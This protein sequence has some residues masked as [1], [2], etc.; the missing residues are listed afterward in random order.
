MRTDC[1]IYS[2]LNKSF[3]SYKNNKSL[4]LIGKTE[5]SYGELYQKIN[6]TIHYLKS[7]GIK[8]ADKIAILSHNMPNWGI[9]YLSATFMGAVVVP[10]LPDFT[11]EQVETILN[12]SEAKMVFVSYRQAYKLETASKKT[13]T[14]IL[15]DLDSITQQT[16]TDECITYQPCEN[17][18]AAII[19]TSGTTG[20]PKGVMLSHKNIA[21]N[22]IAAFKIQ[23]ILPSDKFLS[24]LP[25]S[26]TYENTL[27]FLLSL[28]GGA[29]MHYIDGPPTPALL[30]KALKA[31][32]PTIVNSVPLIIEKIYRQK[33]QPK[34]TK[35][36]TQRI[37]MHVP[38][39]RKTFHKIAGKKLM[40]SFGGNIKF[41]GVGGA[42]LDAKVE[43]FLIEAKF[44]YAIGYGLTETAPLLAGTGPFKTRL[45]AIGPA[46]EN[47]KMEIKNKNKKGFGEIWVNGPNIMQGYYK[48]EEETKKVLVDGWFN[49]GDIG[50]I[51]NK[52]YLYHKGRKKNIIVGANGENIYPE[53]IESVINNFKHVVES[54]VVEKKGQLVAF[55]HFNKDELERKYNDLQEEVTN[56][57]ENKLEDLQLELLNYVNARMN[58]MNKLQLVYIQPQPFQ[59]TPTQ[60]IKRYLY[61]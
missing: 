54:I 48:N 16:E 42:K 41:F 35:S 11:K 19:Y 18:L 47:V 33:I 28:Y 14:L 55:V 56:Y 3:F 13:K 6:N 31:I 43:Q 7:E 30:A 46:V 8:P 26:H 5:L 37:L 32:K 9:V 52:G 57:F 34:L 50:Y 21:S 49:T 12:H 40:E 2:I 4:C 24:I 45:Q 27:S 58:K 53:D 59:K 39:I 22:V 44:P 10:I 38:F 23:E 25:L 60:K 20:T 61:K 36:V 15:N 17:Q 51:D 1:T 29:S